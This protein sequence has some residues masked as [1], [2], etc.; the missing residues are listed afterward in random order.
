MPDASTTTALRACRV[1]KRF[2]GSEALRGVDFSVST[3]EIV[4]LVGENG[5]GKSTLV[6]VLTG[7]HEPSAGTLQLDDRDVVFSSPRDAAERGVAVV[8]QESQ[9]FPALRVW[10]NLAVTSGRIPGPGPFVD[11]GEARRAAVRV[12][13]RFGTRIDPDARVRALLPIER[14]LVEIAR[15]L[16]AHPS[17]L[18]L[19][20]P[21]AALE[22]SES[23]R[24]LA[25]LRELRGQGTGLVLVSHHLDEVEELADRVTVLRDGSVAGELRDGEIDHARM[26]QAMLG[27]AIADDRAA[28]PATGRRPS[29][30]DVLAIRRLRILPSAR[31]VDLTIRRG[32][33]VAVTGLVGAGTSSL[34]EHL[35]GGGP[36]RS[37]GITVAGRP[38][39][40]S[41]SASALRAGIGFLSQ[42]RKRSGS[43]P[44][45]SVSWN[46]GLA[47]LSALCW[48]GFRRDRRID[49]LAQDMRDRLGVR[50]ES[51]R[52]P[53]R[54]LSG[55]NQ[56][57]V[58]IARWL[59][60]GVKILAIDEP[61]QGV[62]I[63]ARAD[64]AGHLR[65]FTA[66]GGT[67]LFGSSDLYEIEELATRVLVLH[68]GDVVADVDA[69][70]RRPSPEALLAAMTSAAS[71]PSGGEAEAS[72]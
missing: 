14:R 2:G 27:H 59:A 25:M 60:T 50:C 40:L 26:I 43:L 38:T 48:N 66:R 44:N 22:R 69:S 42:D 21:T 35:V 12:L 32:E 8:H 10:E 49:G 64:I 37:A 68:R 30:E 3:G 72:G 71:L 16:S 29:G 34:L 47:G 5:A 9:L 1:R 52:Q 19:D 31:P 56:Q 15:A 6:K 33:L 58:L 20:E 67:V 18:L 11:R 46:V 54:T 41:S 45:H 36:A 63:A 24:L 57:K 70:D 13:D 17:F 4:G 55:G 61:T 65:A 23:R 7:V 51:V 62:D 53:M 28:G 39:R